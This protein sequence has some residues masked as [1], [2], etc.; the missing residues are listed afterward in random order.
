MSE[1]SAPASGRGAEAGWGRRVA[2][3][4]IDWLI[5]NLAAFALVRDPAV[6]Q[7]PVTG[8][9]FVPLGIF[10]LEVWVTTAF[11]GA[12]IGQRLRHLV[13]ARVDGRPVGLLR[14]FVRTVGI[15]LV[16]PPLIVG[17]DGRGLHDRVAGTVIVRAR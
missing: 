6:W 1:G 15:L 9:D 12:S 16:V 11:V 4:V 17:S 10:A 14:A 3:L 8:L 5:A 2:A 7:A 13:V